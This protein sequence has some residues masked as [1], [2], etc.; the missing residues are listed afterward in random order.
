VDRFLCKGNRFFGTHSLPASDYHNKTSG[1]E[2]VIY[3]G[4]WL[5]SV[6]PSTLALNL[7]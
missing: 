7:L 2:N 6:C 3:D 5:G 1:E 4:E